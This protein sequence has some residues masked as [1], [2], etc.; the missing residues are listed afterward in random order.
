MSK[1]KDSNL[2]REQPNDKTRKQSDVEGKKNK[3]KLSN[4]EKVKQ[5]NV[6]KNMQNDLQMQVSDRGTKDKKK[7]KV[8]FP[9]YKAEKNTFVEKTNGLVQETT[10]DEIGTKQEVDP[11]NN[12]D[13][14]MD[15]KKKRK[16]KKQIDSEGR[17]Q[18]K[19][20]SDA[21]TE[22]HISNDSKALSLLQPH[23]QDQIVGNQNDI[24]YIKNFDKIGKEVNELTKGKGKV[25]EKF[26]KYHP[27]IP[28]EILSTDLE[29]EQISTIQRLQDS[30][31]AS[32]VH[33]DEENIEE[34]ELSQATLP[35]ISDHEVEIIDVKDKIVDEENKIVLDSFPKY[36]KKEA[37]TEENELSYGRKKDALSENIEEI[38]I[39]RAAL[40][41]N[42]GH[43]VENIKVEDKIIDE[44]NKIISDAFPKYEK[45]EVD[46]EENQFSDEKVLN[47]LQL[48]LLSSFK[49]RD[50]SHYP[51]SSTIAIILLL[52]LIYFLQRKRR[53]TKSQIQLSHHVVITQ[54]K[55]HLAFWSC[56]SH[57]PTHA[58]A[59]S[60][61][62]I[63]DINNRGLPLQSSLSTP[64]SRNLFSF[65]S[66]SRIMFTAIL[67]HM[68]RK[69]RVAFPWIHTFSA[70]PQLVYITHL[71]WQI[72]S[73]EEILYRNNMNY[74]RLI[75]AVMMLIIM[76]KLLML[77]GF[78]S[79]LAR[80]IGPRSYPVTFID[81]HKDHV[82]NK[83]KDV[84][85]HCGSSS[86][87]PIITTLLV[88]YSNLLPHVPIQ[89]FPFIPFIQLP[90]GNLGFL[91]CIVILSTGCSFQFSATAGAL[92]RNEAQFSNVLLGVVLGIFFSWTFDFML[93]SGSYW[94]DSTFFLNILMCA[95]SI[96]VQ[97][98]LGAVE[99]QGPQRYGYKIPCIDYVGWDDDGIIL[100][101]KEC[102]SM[103][104]EGMRELGEENHFSIYS[105][106]T[107]DLEDGSQ[108]DF[109]T[110]NRSSSILEDNFGEEG[111][112]IDW[113]DGG[114]NNSDGF[115]DASMNQELETNRSINDISR[116]LG[117]TSSR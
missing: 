90:A 80:T 33:I 104:K 31:V 29:I 97:Q 43:E 58:R 75:I 22:Q 115:G 28:K 74:V 88:I 112:W 86:F 55:Y 107:I 12:K 93:R 8:Q 61:S 6:D 89:I 113:D 27:T 102:E 46:T 99:P 87:T 26:T 37:D 103:W 41:N 84:N 116:R 5:T 114:G 3:N 91:I 101:K 98:N 79:V 40:Q 15:K 60:E 65:Y 78:E 21:V 100:E 85:H 19:P 66:R 18:T 82:H 1:I 45:M 34:I 4:T 73:F 76:M 50:P 70:F 108:S 57:V 109:F 59:Y 92:A 7:K 13:P 94:I 49:Q 52:H 72:R 20:I 42:L 69:I 23:D 53:T 39:F 47:P 11:F 105:R 95:M 35:S 9:A 68:I 77:R 96:W 10:T 17:S 71:L 24:K 106:D 48:Q 117:H 16:K 62:N 14:F 36:E 25:I 38:K 2:K 44:E 64:S 81:N 30:L 54:R 83:M 32:K 56:I 51:H 63:E 111:S 110:G 67:T